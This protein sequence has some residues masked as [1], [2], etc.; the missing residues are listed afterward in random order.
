VK[1]EYLPLDVGTPAF[2]VAAPNDTLV[3]IGYT[4]EIF[5]TSLTWALARIPES[6]AA[7]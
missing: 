6:T 5:R 2:L 1:D 3:V 4:K 7:L